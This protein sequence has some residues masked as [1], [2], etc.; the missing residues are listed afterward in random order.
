MIIE[1]VLNQVL[2]GF[3]KAHSTSP[4]QNFAKIS[5]K[6]LTQGELLVQF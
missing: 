3:R 4:F 5:K 6:S 2:C 1:I